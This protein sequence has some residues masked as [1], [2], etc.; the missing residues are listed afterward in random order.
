V[1]RAAVVA[2]FRRAVA[3]ARLGKRWRPA[4]LIGGPLA[5]AG[6]G[7]LVLFGAIDPFSAPLRLI[8]VPEILWE[9]A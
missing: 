7:I 9:A 2:T 5:V 3:P 8:T 6:G 1:D 4:G